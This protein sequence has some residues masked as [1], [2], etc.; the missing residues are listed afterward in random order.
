[1]T[2]TKKENW[3]LVPLGLDLYNGLPGVA[4]F[5][6]YLGT[7]SEETRYTALARATVT[8]IRRQLSAFP[9]HRFSI[10]AFDGLGGIVYLFTHLGVMWNDPELLQEAKQ[11]AENSRAL[12]FYD[13]K[14]DITSGSAGCIMSLLALQ[15]V[16]PDEKTLAAAVECG[17]HLLGHA[18]S[19]QDGIAWPAYFP[20]KGPL[21][22]LSHGASGIAWALLELSE[23]SGE[24]RFREAALKGFR[25]ENTL[26][27]SDKKNWPD[28]REM[29]N[30]GDRMFMVGWCHGAPGIAL[31]RLRALKYVEDASV[32]N[33]IAAGLE[34]TLSQGFRGDHSLCHGSLGN[35]EPLLQASELLDR[36]PW[37][38][39][40]NRVSSAILQSIQDDGWFCGVPLGVESP[41]LM[42]GLAGIGYGL[43]RLADPLKIPSLLTLAP[44][45]SWSKRTS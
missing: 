28:L 10:G 14:F 16:A 29:N 5:L 27:S 41:G 30:G 11:I 13:R 24:K 3:S 35:L 22:G 44:P 6:A 2:L 43:L 33:D 38:C 21:T 23:Q 39:H 4:L 12:I 8:T 32:R 18:Q 17:A 42:T 40:V 26:F 25:Y 36:T 31:V 20:A 7:V 19:L 34:T 1:L 45:I 9:L 37:T 15:S